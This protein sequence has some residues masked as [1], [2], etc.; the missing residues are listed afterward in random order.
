MVW[1]VTAVIVVT[2]T[3]PTH[4][5]RRHTKQEEPHTLRTEDEK[6]VLVSAS[7]DFRR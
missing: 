1:C 3:G 6:D 4:F 5:S 7:P 2:L